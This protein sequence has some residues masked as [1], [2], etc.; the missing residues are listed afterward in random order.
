M[1]SLSDSLAS[2]TGEAL[3][4]VGAPFG[5]D[6]SPLHILTT[7]STGYPIQLLVVL[8]TKVLIVL[9]EVAPGGQ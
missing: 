6:H 4:M 8:L 2:V 1:C 3:G 9:E 5:T 7:L